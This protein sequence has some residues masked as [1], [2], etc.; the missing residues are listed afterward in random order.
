MRTSLEPGSP[1]FEAFDSVVDELFDASGLRVETD[2][3]T[4]YQPVRRSEETH[5]PW[6]DISFRILRRERYR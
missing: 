6:G 3:G 5:Q 1:D 4:A 2:V